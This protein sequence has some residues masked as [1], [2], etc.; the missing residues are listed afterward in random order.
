MSNNTPFEDLSKRQE[1]HTAHRTQSE[2]LQMVE[3]ALELYARACHAGT[4]PMDLH[5]MV[6]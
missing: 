3:A 6:Q 5:G 1:G 4:G 2:A